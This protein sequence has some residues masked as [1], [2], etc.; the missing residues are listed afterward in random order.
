MGFI[1]SQVV[2]TVFNDLFS[3]DSLAN[4]CLVARTTLQFFFKTDHNVVA[5]LTFL[6]EVIGLPWQLLSDTTSLGVNAE[7]LF[8]SC[9]SNLFD[10]SSQEAGE[11]RS[12][13]EFCYEYKPLLL[14]GGGGLDSVYV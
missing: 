10:F 11:V 3:D 1:S 7:D 8:A 14:E 9:Q 6:H 5:R 2:Q 13:G 4:P 12:L